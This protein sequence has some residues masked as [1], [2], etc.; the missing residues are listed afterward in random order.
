[1]LVAPATD[2]AT[3]VDAGPVRKWSGDLGDDLD[4]SLPRHQ[5]APISR[6]WLRATLDATF[7][8]RGRRVWTAQV[9]LFEPVMSLMKYSFWLPNSR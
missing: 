1:M 7:A 3:M 9:R 6:R 8:W 4:A 2:A 5:P